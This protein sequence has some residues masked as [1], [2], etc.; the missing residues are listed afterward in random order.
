MLF[1]EKFK[2]L[3]VYRACMGLRQFA[4]EIGVKP[5]EL[6]DLERGHMKPPDDDEWYWKMVYALCIQSDL[7]QQMVFKKLWKEP[8]VMQYMAEGLPAIPFP[9]H[10]EDGSTLEE[11]EVQSLA[12]WLNDE[13]VEHNKKARKYNESR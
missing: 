3:R 10:R 6:S 13:A 2:E 5:S 12:Q 4:N 8:F 11:D 7:S 9:P 1:G